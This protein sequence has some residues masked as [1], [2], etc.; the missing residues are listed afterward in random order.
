M[1]TLLRRNFCAKRNENKNSGQTVDLNKNS[2]ILRKEA[3]RQIKYILLSR[4][5]PKRKISSRDGG[6]C[7]FPEIDK[8]ICEELEDRW[9]LIF[10]RG[11][12]RRNNNPNAEWLAIAT[13]DSR[14]GVQ[15]RLQ[16]AETAP[17]RSNVRSNVRRNWLPRDGLSRFIVDYS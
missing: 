7:F 9:K 13:V 10:K 11:E 5:L 6:V 15:E 3:G 2:Q 16:D 8:I 17:F 12:R 1:N 4:I 14:F